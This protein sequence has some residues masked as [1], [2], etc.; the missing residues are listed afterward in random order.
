MKTYNLSV[1][2]EYVRMGFLD[3]HDFTSDLEVVLQGDIEDTL[4]LN[5]TLGEFKAVEECTIEVK[6]KENNILIGISNIVADNGNYAVDMA[7]R[8][9][10]RY[11]SVLS[12]I[13]QQQNVNQNRFHTQLGYNRRNITVTEFNYKNYDDFIRQP[14]RVVDENGNVTLHLSDRISIGESAHSVL[15]QTFQ[16]S[17][18]K[19]I[20]QAISTEEGEYPLFLLESFYRALGFQD[21]VSKFF[22]LF[23]II[24]SV[25]KR[26]SALIAAEK[27]FDD[28]KVEGILMDLGVTLEKFTSSKEYK[29]RLLNSFK[30]TLVNFTDKTRANKL[31]LILMNYFSISEINKGSI[32]FEITKELVDQWLKLRHGLVHAKILDEEAKE[33]LRY[34]TNQLLVLCET[35][36]EKVIEPLLKDSE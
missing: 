11:V 27:V 13:I 16:T 10:D 2:L 34:L 18:F 6:Q 31:V 21:Y 5:I 7:T 33:D 20:N 15:K 28:E 8:I 26:Y 22:N 1:P 12:F 23:V 24:E 14:R 3:E 4:M 19:Q 25:E 32:Q 36:I 9:F 17:S 35:I 30:G 29:S